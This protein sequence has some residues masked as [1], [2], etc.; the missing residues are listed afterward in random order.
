MEFASYTGQRWSA[1]LGIASAEPNKNGAP[2]WAQPQFSYRFS[3][4]PPVEVY[5]LNGYRAP[6]GTRDTSINVISEHP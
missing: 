4:I 6:G 3:G 1:T 2:L 5:E